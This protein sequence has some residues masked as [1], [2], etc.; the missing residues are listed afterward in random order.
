M[1]SFQL[2]NISLGI[3]FQIPDLDG[4][5]QVKINSADTG[6]QLACVQADLS[7]GKTVYQKGVGWATGV[8]AGL[9]L[10]VSAIVSGL[11]HS[12]TASHIAANAMSL[13]GFFQAQAFFGMTAVHLPPIASS[14]TQNFQW[15]MGIIRLGFIQH[16][17]TWYQ[18]STGGTP[19]TVLSSVATTSVIVEKR[20]LGAMH[21]ISRAARQALRNPMI[22][23]VNM[24]LVKRA[25]ALVKRGVTG[26]LG[27]R[28]ATNDYNGTV[29]TIKGIERVGFRADI[30]LSN[31]FMTGYI[32][33]MI[34]FC[35][36]I[37]GLVLFKFVLEALVR[38]GKVKSDKFQDFRTGFATTLRG[39]CFRLVLIGFP[40]MVIL[41]FW[42][43]TKQDSAGEMA[44]AVVT[45]FTMLIMLVWACFRVWMLARRSIA[46]HKNP[47]YILYSDPE[48]LH[49]WGFL[50]VQFKAT[51]YWWV[52]PLL[53]YILLKGLF[54]ALAQNSPIT[55]AIAFLVLEAALLIGL[56]I[57]RP[58]MDKKTNAFNIS[59]SAVNFVSSIFL[60][61]FTDIFGVPVSSSTYRSLF[62]PPDAHLGPRRWRNG[63]HLLH[64][65]RRVRPHPRPHGP[66]RHNLRHCPKEPR[67]P[68]STHARRPRLL[69]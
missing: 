61:F 28:A 12:N 11:G 20:D 36:V 10:L 63:R 69:H 35:A 27:K 32:F 24:P 1:S 59:I 68:L 3:A 7:N 64:S 58:Y 51:T 47:A 33:L 57:T 46:A 48:C 62:T 34:F 13:F 23:A 30:E 38:S 15:S 5:V 52:M 18:Q 53:A 56:S 45:V 17:A 39:I 21:Y 40:Q 29:L 25:S 8:V 42:E 31:I 41:G 6:E 44:L 50:Y 4:I 14:W 66:H 26:M 43:L 2:A 65:Q 37:L 16:I 49:K 67:R 55:Q 60:L 9:A 22:K 19:S 54:V